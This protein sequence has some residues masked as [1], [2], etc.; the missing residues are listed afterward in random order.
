MQSKPYGY[1]D[2]EAREFVITR[3][4]TPIPWINYLG[5]EDYLG[6]IS[7]TAGGYSFYR[8]ARLR[9]L[10]RYHYNAIPKD[11]PGRYIYVCDGKNTW[12]PGFKPV[13]TKLDDYKCRHGLGY[14]VIEGALDEL[15]V[16]TTYFVP[17]GKNAEVWSVQVTN[18]S[19]KSKDIDIFSYVEFC[20]YDALDDA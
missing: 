7:N 16:T 6:L 2:N 11:N 3:P 20:L 10:T 15:L 13:R 5:C 19:S 12:N 1:F 9:R 18:K 4:D 14:S 17:A 8:D